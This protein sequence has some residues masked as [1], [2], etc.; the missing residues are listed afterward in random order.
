[1]HGWVH[2]LHA[3]SFLSPGF[4]LVLFFRTLKDVTP[5]KLRILFHIY[6]QVCRSFLW[7]LVFIPHFQKYGAVS[8]TA[9]H[10]LR[11]C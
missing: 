6:V 7:D 10:F 8:L 5:T 9:V 2:V 11:L 3:T 4:Q 1:M